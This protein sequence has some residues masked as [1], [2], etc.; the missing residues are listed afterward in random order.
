MTDVKECI[1]RKAT[2]LKTAAAAGVLGLLLTACGGGETPE[3]GSTES[4]ESNAATGE[5]VFP[6]MKDW[7]GCDA[8]DNLQPL[9]DYLGVEA[10][11][12]GELIN[13]GIGEGIDGEAMTCSGMLDLAAYEHAEYSDAGRAEVQMGIVPWENADIAAE[14]YQQR[15]DMLEDAQSSG[16]SEYLNETTG[17]LSGTWDESYFQT[18]NESETGTTN[19]NAYGRNGQWILY[20]LLKVTPDPGLGAEDEPVYPHSEEEL[21]T[22]V[23]E[24]YMPQTQSEILAK[25]ESEQ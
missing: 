8:L 5:D 20:I 19:I 21:K 6:I 11:A 17:A 4:G 22:W 10:I 24:E 16:G 9:Q 23:V 18:S 3:G 12:N 7:K 14:N 25:I 2:L 15:L 13:A 1:M